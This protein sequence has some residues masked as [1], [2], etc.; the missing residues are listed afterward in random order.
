MVNY[1]AVINARPEK[2]HKAAEEWVTLAKHALR[3]AQ[4]IRDNG[5]KPLADHWSDEVGQK[6]A[7]DFEEL[8]NQ[9]ES[10]YDI[11]LGGK[12]LCEAVADSME[13]ALSSAREINELAQRH[14]LRIGSDGLPEGAPMPGE[15]PE[16][17]HAWERIVALRD[18]VLQQVDEADNT[19]AAKFAM[20][21]DK[22]NVADPDEALKVQNKASQAEMEILGAE[23]P[24]DAGP[25]TQRMWWNGLSEKQR[26]D[27]MLADPV[28]LSKLEGLP[29]S[30][31]QE[32]RGADGKFDR[33][34]MVE[35]ALENWDQKD[36]VDFGN[37][38][39]NFVSES[40]AHAGMK[41]KESIWGTRADDT[42][43]KGNPTEID[44]PGFRDIDRSLG[45][46][47]TWAGAENQQNFMLDHGGEEVPRDQVRPGDIIYYEQSGD[48]DAIG[49]GN[50]HHAAIVTGVM[51]DGEIKYTQH[52][53][54]YR[55]VS[56]DGRLP[57]TE[58]AEGKQN[59]R[60]VRPHPDWY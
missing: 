9:L 27:L 22:V 55:N 49:K 57:N 32:M 38:C 45:F 10:A 2:W 14:N 60:I 1:E 26:H 51:P 42:W 41:E 16:K 17:L 44:L 53:D 43:M 59:V 18:H 15:D 36:D 29:E 28:A 19:A 8:A 25:M 56:L 58:K 46:S 47:K 13:T 31:K 33:V 21:T 23:I 48:N 20:L 52:S 11:L 34:K 35:Y 37:N 40:L 54:P 39:T 6:A 4:D 50:T 7:K 30:V 12:M 3:A 5:T 24:R